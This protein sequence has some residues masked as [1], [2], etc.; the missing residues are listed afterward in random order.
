MTSCIFCKII[1]GEIPSVKLY[2][3]EQVLAFF[4]ISQVTKGHTLVIPK[5]HH[6]SI[7]DLPE[8]VAAHTYSVIPKI[9]SALKQTF[10]PK[11]LNIVN[12]NGE[13]AGQTVFH[14]HVHLVPRYGESGIHGSLWGNTSNDV[15]INQLTAYAKQ[16]T[17]KLAN[18]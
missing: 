16:V 17:G 8:N 7:Y 2:E 1:D 15:D 3:D 6:E 13:A 4:D 9:A 12:N 14:Y 10:E 11:G 5:K 18:T